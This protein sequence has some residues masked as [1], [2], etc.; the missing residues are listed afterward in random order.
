M[1]RISRKFR[2]GNKMEQP[3]YTK[4]AKG[5]KKIAN[6]LAACEKLCAGYLNYD[7][8]GRQ[9]LREFVNREDELIEALSQ[10][11]WRVKKWMVSKDKAML[12]FTMSIV[13]VLLASKH[14]DTEATL[15]TLRGL[16]EEVPMDEGKK[17]EAYKYLLDKL[18]LPNEN[19][20]HHLLT[21]ILNEKVQ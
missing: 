1:R 6:M 12:W 20:E 17:R 5:K 19:L 13:S 14:F 21:T 18:L 8:E 4:D 2:F 7:F 11:P 16:W 10:Y 15:N 3:I 9:K